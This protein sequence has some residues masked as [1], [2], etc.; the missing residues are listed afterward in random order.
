MLCEG[1]P[2]S[3]AKELF[4]SGLA[5]CEEYFL[6]HKEIKVISEDIQNRLVER[7]EYEDTWVRKRECLRRYLESTTSY[8]TSSDT[9]TVAT[10]IDA[11]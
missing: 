6:R 8:C 4:A 5:A 3:K 10:R 2:K 11:N 7:L 1:V 9:S